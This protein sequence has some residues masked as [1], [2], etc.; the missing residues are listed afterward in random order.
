MGLRNSLG[1]SHHD[2]LL[3]IASFASFAS[4][5]HSGMHCL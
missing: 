5:A 4:F 1:V 3:E 2:V